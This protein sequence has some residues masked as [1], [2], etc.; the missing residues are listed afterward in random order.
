MTELTTIKML[1]LLIVA[2]G[3]P[4]DI[5]GAMSRLKTGFDRVPGNQPRVRS[6]ILLL[7]KFEQVC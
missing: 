7:K 4:K 1:L 6:C 2:S 5:F 3:T